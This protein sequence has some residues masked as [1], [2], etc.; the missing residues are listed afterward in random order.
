MRI[1]KAFLGAVCLVF[2]APPVGAQDLP[3]LA[4]ELAE[5]SAAGGAQ[6]LRQRFEDNGRERLL[7]PR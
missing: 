1:M 4:D 5:A 7:T 3:L 6:G 2:A